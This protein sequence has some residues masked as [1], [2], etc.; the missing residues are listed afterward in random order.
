MH[1][2][3]I[4]QHEI[5]RGWP[6]RNAKTPHGRFEERSRGQDFAGVPAEV[7]FV[8]NSGGETCQGY[9]VHTVGGDRPPNPAHLVL[10]GG[11]NPE[12]QA[13][14]PVGFRKCACDNHVLRLPDEI[15]HGFAV[16][17]EVCLVYQNCGMRS[18]L[19]DAD[20]IFTASCLAGGTIGI[21]DGDEPSGRRDG[22][23]QRLE[24]KAK[25]VFCSD[26]DDRRRSSR[27]ID[28]VHGVGR[29]G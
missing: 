5:G 3:N 6:V 13:G 27:C 1:G 10:V 12:A 26:P 11:N 25:P 19:D 17:M 15:D 21:G 24:R 20:Q 7:V 16:E 14:E 28:L 22:A 4:H 9:G 8:F 2:T 23:E 18:G 29:D